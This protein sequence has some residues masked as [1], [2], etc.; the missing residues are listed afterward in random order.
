VFSNVQFL[1]AEFTESSQ[2]V[3]ATGQSFVGNTPAY[4]PDW[5][6][7]GGITFQKERCFRV[8]F[9]G[10]HVSDQFWQDSNQPLLAAGGVVSVPAVIPSYTIW[11]LS[12][13]VYLTKN[14]R[15][16]AGIS[17]LTDEKYYSR[18]VLTGLIDPA[19]MRTGYAGVS[20][21]F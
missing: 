5:I 11:N 1:D 3:A 19:P 12:G 20:V 9:S 15:L 6:W 8:T 16:M 18:A 13:E 21:E 4:A 2:V 14:V 17:N 7:K 10:V